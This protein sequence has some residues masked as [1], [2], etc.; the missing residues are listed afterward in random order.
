MADLLGVN[1]LQN[2]IEADGRAAG[3]VGVGLETELLDALLV[4]VGDHEQQIGMVHHVPHG[5]VA[6]AARF[7]KR[8]ERIDRGKAQRC[9]W[10]MWA[11]GRGCPR[12]NDPQ[13]QRQG[14]AGS[15]A[16]TWIFSHAKRFPRGSEASAL[17]WA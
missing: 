5:P 9:V 3:A 7:E 17:R 14:R 13:R 12:A 16:K 1:L 2:L 10:F 4:Q 15:V 6:G 11:A 8:R